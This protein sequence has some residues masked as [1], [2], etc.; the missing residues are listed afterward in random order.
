MNGPPSGDWALKVRSEV[1]KDGEGRRLVFPGILDYG[2]DGRPGGRDLAASL[3]WNPLL[4]VG[5]D[6]MASIHFTLP[7]TPAKF[8]VAVD[9][10]GGGRIGAG[11]AEIVSRVPF[12]M[13]PELPPEVNSGDRIDVPLAVRNGTDGP[14]PLQLRLD[15]GPRVQ[16]A[17]PTVREL[18]L[19]AGAAARESFAVNAVGQK[20]DCELAFRGTAGPWTDTA[21][22]ELRIISPGF[23]RSA[24]YS[25]QLD[26]RQEVVV[27]LPERWMPGSL[28]VTLTVFPSV[29]ADLRQAIEGM[30]QAPAGGFEEACALEE[31]NV[32]AM[33]YLVEQKLADPA[34]TRLLKDSLR[35][36]YA[37]LAGFECRQ[38]GFSSFGAGP[39]RPGPHR[40]GPAATSRIG[41][42]L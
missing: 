13:A 5:P 34:L 10:Q 24:S 42:R 38:G 31:L 2:D 41:E 12:R 11:Q 3:Y 40:A 19:A 25:G 21:R 20:G 7:A 30:K 17:G 28:E 1:L 35:E 16:L 27:R 39:G 23:P 26:G 36:G 6:G 15:H 29:L 33:R 9:A 8:R 4:E 37:R 32:L 18:N 14:L 22:R